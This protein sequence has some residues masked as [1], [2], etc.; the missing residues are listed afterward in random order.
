[1]LVTLMGRDCMLNGEA[2]AETQMTPNF[3]SVNADGVEKAD[4]NLRF[5]Y[6]EASR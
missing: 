3:S 1:M 5:F 2:R 6:C 4:Q